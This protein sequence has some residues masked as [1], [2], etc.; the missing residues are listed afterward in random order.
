MTATTTTEAPPPSKWHTTFLQ[1]TQGN[2]I[3]SVLAVVLA[4]I[5]GGIMIA[6]TDEDVQAAAGYFFSRPGDTFAAIWDAVSGAYVALFQSSVYN[7]GAPTFARAIR[8]LTET[9]TFATPSSPQ[10]SASRWRSASACS[11]SVVAVRC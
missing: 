11:T 7:F 8:P 1:I 6:V 3:I 9:L 2:A 4:L 5:V 10:D